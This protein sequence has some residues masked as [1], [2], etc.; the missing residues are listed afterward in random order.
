MKIKAQAIIKNHHYQSDPKLCATYNHCIHLYHLA[1]PVKL[2][3]Y[4]N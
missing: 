4:S 3:S 1:T 2:Y